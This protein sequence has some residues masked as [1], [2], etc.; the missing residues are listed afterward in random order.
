[1]DLVYQG[2]SYKE[3]GEQY[4]VPKT[5]LFKKCHGQQTGKVGAPRVISEEIE[6]RLVT[7]CNVFAKWRMPVCEDMFLDLVQQ[8]LNRVNFSN[9]RLKDNRPTK[10][11]LQGLKER[12]NLSLRLADNVIPGK[13]KVGPITLNVSKIFYL[14]CTLTV[15]L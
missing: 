5:T 4:N 2:V 14:L 10:K 13:C 3:A 11:W 1:M 7:M 9:S 6:N 8:V 12:H 15:P